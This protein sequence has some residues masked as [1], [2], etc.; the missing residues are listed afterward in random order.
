VPA[1]ISLGA[2]L[3]VS[4]PTSTNSAVQSVMRANRRRD[5]KPEVA[6]RSA[7]HRRG[8]RFRN[9]ASIVTEERRV[10]VDVA[11]P[12]HRIAVFVDGCFWHCCPGHGT[13][14]RSNSTYWRPKLERNVQRDAITN[15]LLQR[16]GW[17]VIRVWE[18]QDPNEAARMIDQVVRRSV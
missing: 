17:R 4:Y 2:G 16:A 14:P 13:R 7:L 12:R 1:T 11:L 15:Q 10:R 18:H 5:T 9:D 6:L 8:L 3:R